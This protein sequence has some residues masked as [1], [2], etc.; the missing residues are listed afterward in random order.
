MGIYGKPKVSSQD[1]RSLPTKPLVGAQP[2]MKELATRPE[3]RSAAATTVDRVAIASVDASRPRPVGP[4]E[5]AGP[6]PI[7]A[8][9]TQARRSAASIAAR[10]ASFAGDMTISR[11]LLH[12]GRDADIEKARLQATFFLRGGKGGGTQSSALLEEGESMPSYTVG[13]GGGAAETV[14][15]SSE[16]SHSA[17]AAAQ[18]IARAAKLP[19]PVS[20]RLRFTPDMSLS[21]QGSP[22]R[23]NLPTEPKKVVFKGRHSLHPLP[24]GEC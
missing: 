19:P 3:A 18:G 6:A 12:P 9:A 7:D 11:P 24:I 20:P 21:V 10:E 2:R 22:P 17:S 4:R 23:L 1:W 8:M 13:V 5:P 14:A 16:L 15:Q